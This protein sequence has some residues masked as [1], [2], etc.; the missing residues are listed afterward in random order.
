MSDDLVEP[1]VERSEAIFEAAGGGDVEAIERAASLW[2][3]AWRELRKRWI[4]WIAAGL[5]GLFS[6]MA[7]VPQVFVA[8]SPATHDPKECSL[9]AADGTF[10]DRLRPSSEHWFGTDLQGCDY[11]A[12]VIYGARVS[13][14]IGIGVTAL[15]GLIGL[16]LGGIAGFYGGWFDN[17]ISRFVDILFAI[18]FLV[19]AILFLNVIASDGSRGLGHVLLVLGVFGWP[20]LSRLFRASVIQAKAQDYVEAAR[21]VGASNMR[22]LVRHIL[23]NAIA[24]AIVYATIA[25]GGVIAAEATLSFLGVGLQLPAISWGLMINNAQTRILTDPHLL[26]FPGVFLS[27]TVLGFLLLGDAVRDALDP[28]LR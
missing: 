19:A 22:I 8:P 1:E 14:V 6:V 3:D 24:P 28:R 4:F 15:A 13:M 11:F 5:I 17:L 10:Q 23:P 21:A 2:S 18:P 12:R 9:R 20:T 25:I 7:I 27:L 26:L 16:T